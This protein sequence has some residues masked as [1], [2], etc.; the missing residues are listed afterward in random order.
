MFAVCRSEGNNVASVS[1]AE[2]FA[3]WAKRS[4]SSDGGRSQT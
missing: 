3:G 1:V 2:P 4:K